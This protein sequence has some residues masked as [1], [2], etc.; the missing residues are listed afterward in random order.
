MTAADGGRVDT[1]NGRTMNA[2]QDRRP[3]PDVWP[4][5]NMKNRVIIVV[6]AILVVA[7]VALYF[8]IYK[9]LNYITDVEILSDVVVGPTWSTFELPN[10]I[11]ISQ[12]INQINIDTQSPY[13]FRPGWKK[14]KAADGTEFMPEVEIFLESGEIISLYSSGGRFYHEHQFAAFRNDDH[15]VKGLRFKQLRIRSAH[16]F[17]IKTIWFSSYDVKDMP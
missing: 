17:A 2:A 13:E 8:A 4:D 10:S 3:E 1:T 14:I 7:L 6:A 16:E 5:W 11:V 9:K 12:D 15:L